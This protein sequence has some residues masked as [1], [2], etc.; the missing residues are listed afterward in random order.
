MISEGTE[1]IELVSAEEREMIKQQ[2]AEGNEYFIYPGITSFQK[3]LKNLL[4]AFSA[5]KKR[6]RSGMQLLFVG[7]RGLQFED[8]QESL[9][10]YKFKKEIKLLSGLS[11]PENIK[12]MTSA[13]AMVYPVEYE[14]CANG[15]LKAMQCEVPVLASSSGAG[16]EFCG[17][18]ALYFQP[19]DHKDIAEKM[20]EIF[21]DESLRKEL[22]NKGK[23]RVQNF[24][25]S[26][27]AD[28]FW[29]VIENTAAASSGTV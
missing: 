13:Y 9:A 20:M 6:Q 15:F 7:E 28:A 27:T 21:R 2:Y 1:R 22:V 19:A 5:F 25:W 12:L 4:R 17:D 8:F 29:K 18:A 26:D 14:M 11:E 24:N 3:N 10:L 16:P 23:T